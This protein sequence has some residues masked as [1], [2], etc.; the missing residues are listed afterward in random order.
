MAMPSKMSVGVSFT[1]FHHPGAKMVARID[2]VQAEPV[3]IHQ[4]FTYGAVQ[5]LNI[6]VHK[7]K[8]NIIVKIVFFIV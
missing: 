7:T 6:T 2:N 5:G 8:A 4:K 1:L 3:I